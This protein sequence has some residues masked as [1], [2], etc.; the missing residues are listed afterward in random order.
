MT[1]SPQQL[2]RAELAGMQAYQ[3]ANAEGLIKLDAMENPYNFPA[4]LQE[5]WLRTLK[6]LELNRYPDPQASQ[7][8]QDFRTTYAISS[9]L[10]MLFGNGSDELIQLLIL[11]IAK[12]D[13][14]ILT[15]TPSFSM[16]KIIAEFVGVRIIE[17]P[18]IAET[19]A[20][21]T[22]EMCKKIQQYNPA[23]VFLACPNNPTGTLWPQAEVE[24][25]VQQASGLVV[26]DEAYAPFA[27]YSMLPLVENYSHVLMLR[28]L[29]K[30]GLAGVRLGWLLGAEQWLNELDKLRLPYN[31]NALTQASVSFALNNI[32]IF[33]A[34]AKLICQQ[35]QQLNATMQEMEGIQ[36]FPSE[37]NF[38]LF[39]IL[40][41][42][43]DVV[44]KRLIDNKILI[45]DVAN[46]KLL[47]NCL[48]VTVGAEN[49]NRAFIA[50]LK[51]S[52]F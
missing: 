22:N 43:A 1:I 11:A 46:N 40:N 20:L 24:K 38:I 12:P 29:S 21:Q 9:N 49:E 10:E 41:S 45:K 13:A 42:P 16:Y 39:K 2:L 32:S 35:R 27:A 50:A 14:C 19:F 30:M 51:N 34:Q 8:K 26:I 18:L 36:V 25:I 23:L 3:V 52:L 7:L 37:A 48:R 4:S 47:E 6:D 5:Q 33:D 44:F 15:V 17:V 28:T 31:I